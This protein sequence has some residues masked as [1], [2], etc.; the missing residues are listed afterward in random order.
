MGT[1]IDEYE[2]GKIMVNLS[3]LNA[4]FSKYLKVKGGG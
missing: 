4:S 1:I 3:H 2:Y